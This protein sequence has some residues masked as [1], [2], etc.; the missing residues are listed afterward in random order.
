[1]KC[2]YC[3]VEILDEVKVCPLCQMALQKDKKETWEL[4]VG[5]PD[6]VEKHRKKRMFLKIFIYV[7]ILLEI[8]LAVINYLTYEKISFPWSGVTGVCILY[9]FFA[10]ATLV[11]HEKGHVQEIYIQIPA[12]MIFLLVLDYTMG[13]IGWSLE[14]GLPIVLLGLLVLI[15]VCMC[16]NHKNWQIYMVLQ[17]F[18][19]LFSVIDLWLV[20]SGVV[21]YQVLPLISLGVSVALFLGTLLI[22]D[23]KAMNELKRK[24]HV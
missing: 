5:Y 15:I 16:I 11:R 4:Y 20:L 24:F 1:M 13:W 21:K 22:G 14:Y 3:K 7:A 6:M 9:V 19:L 12:V 17:L 10:I 18:T 23:R 2:S 8:L